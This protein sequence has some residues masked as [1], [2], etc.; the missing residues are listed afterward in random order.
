M[1]LGD[2][3]EHKPTELSGGQMQRVAI[4]RA[5]AVEPELIV[6]DEVTSALDV[7]VQA[8]VLALLDD[9]LIMMIF[10]SKVY[11]CNKTG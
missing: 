8:R 6:C 9:L 5:L 3:V 2:R 11:T 4:A 7:S 10:Y 1:G